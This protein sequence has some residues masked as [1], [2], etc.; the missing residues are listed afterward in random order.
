MNGG[1]LRISRMGDN[2]GFHE[3]GRIKDFKNGGELRIS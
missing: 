2:L 1:E 3:W